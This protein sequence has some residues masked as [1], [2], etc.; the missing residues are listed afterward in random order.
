MTR[1]YGSSGF[2]VLRRA[3][4]GIP[5][6][7][8]RFAEAP[9]ALAFASVSPLLGQCEGEGEKGRPP[10]VRARAEGSEACN[11][12]CLS[13]Q[14]PEEPEYNYSESERNP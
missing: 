2:C 8:A 6:F 12:A 10:F 7:T 14:D 3:I 5:Y 9:F 11:R 1:N 13:A 4:A